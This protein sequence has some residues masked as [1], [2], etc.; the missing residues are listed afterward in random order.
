MKGKKKWLWLMAAAGLAAIAG[1]AVLYWDTLLIYM[2]PKVVLG[3]ALTAAFSQLQQRFE[4]DPLGIVLKTLDP[5]GKQT[6][7]LVLETEDPVLGRIRYDM[8]AQLQPHVFSAEGV[9]SAEGRDLDLSIYMDPDFMAVSSD[10]LV[11][12][13]YYG[14][15]YDTFLQDIRSIPLLNWMIGEAVLSKWDASVQSI[16]QKMQKDYPIPQIPS[17][18][19]SD[20][21]KLLLALI[22]TPADVERTAVLVH[23]QALECY[24]ITYALSGPQVLEVLQQFIALDGAQTASVT[25][26]FYLHEQAVV[27]ADAEIEAGETLY[28]L[29]VELGQDVQNDPLAVKYSEKKGS[30]LCQ[31]DFSVVTSHREDLYRESWEIQ[32]TGEAVTVFSYEWKENTGDMV[33]TVNG[34]ESIDLNLTES[35]TGLYL[36]TNELNRLLAIAAGQPHDPQARQY[37]GSI[38]VSRGAEIAVPEYKNLNQWS[39]DDFL[40]LMEGLGGL[41]GLKFS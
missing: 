7:A 30:D 33:L 2:A 18:T 41:I 23:D 20:L 8:H 27:L 6:A 28:H 21:Q 17:I 14:I 24:R 37:R 39:M 11:R 4:G 10:D 32:R 26:A 36:E 3:D 34:S 19:Q 5:E 31:L 35:P 12:G 15:T 13:S 29:Q 40:I 1:A 38:R 22:A 9:V 16:Q 25:A